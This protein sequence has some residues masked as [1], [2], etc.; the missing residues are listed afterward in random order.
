[1]DTTPLPWSL[2]LIHQS[3]CL[4]T[5][6]RLLERRA[7]RYESETGRT[8]VPT[9]GSARVRQLDWEEGGRRRQAAVSPASLAP[10]A[11]RALGERLATP[12]LASPP[13]VPAAPM[14]RWAPHRRLRVQRPDIANVDC[15]AEKLL[16][17]S[18]IRQKTMQMNT[19]LT[20]KIT[21]KIFER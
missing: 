21:C 1:M 14:G 19:Q 12:T 13:S 4:K 6:P 10:N 17:W 9:V 18:S 20:A 3:F 16:S 8:A 2:H 15:R 7:V 11:N 5:L